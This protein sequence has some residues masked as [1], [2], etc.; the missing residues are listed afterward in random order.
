[1][2]IFRPIL[3]DKEFALEKRLRLFDTTMAGVGFILG[4]GIYVLIGVAASNAGSAM[5]LSFLLAGLAALASGLSYAELSSLFPVAESEYRYSTEGLNRGAGFFS[6]ISVILALTIGIAGVS[7]GFA[8][9]FSELFSIENTFLIALGVVIFFALLNWF[10][11]KYSA[12]VNLVCTIASIVG[13]LSIVVLAFFNTGVHNPS[14][15]SMPTGF[16]GIL[17]GA[18]LIFFAFLGFEGIVKMADETKNARKVIPRAVILSIIISTVVYV[19]VAIASISVLPWD[20]LATSSAPL[21]DVAAAVLGDKAFVFLSIIA[22]L[23][24]ANT[25][26]M[27][28]LSSSRGFY[29]FGQIF[30]QFKWISKIGKRNTPLRAIILTSIIAILFLFFKDISVIVGFTNFLIFT[31]FILIN[32]SVIRLRFKKPKL[33]RKFKIPLSIK[34]VPVF[35][36]IGILIS[37]VLMFNLDTIHIISGLIASG[38]ILVIYRLF[39]MKEKR[40]TYGSKK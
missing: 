22:L 4:A 30:K 2:S 39:E 9:Y 7:L 33:K 24:T 5:W 19:A 35:P 8:G 18:S 34:G 17:G 36:I 16:S 31:T 20:K 38:A 21:A 13:L 1:M 23:S 6:Y 26:I 10:S 40:L 32:I 37:L 28:I 29:G 25:V 14:Y 11:T 3:K 15:F 27:G 12:K